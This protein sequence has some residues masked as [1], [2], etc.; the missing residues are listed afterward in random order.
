MSAL[1][2][3]FQPPQ[4]SRNQQI[5]TISPPSNGESPYCWMLKPAHAST[6]DSPFVESASPSRCSMRVDRHV[7][8]ATTR[9]GTYLVLPNHDHRFLLPLL[10]GYS[11]CLISG[12]LVHYRIFFEFYLLLI[13]LLVTTNASNTSIRC[14]QP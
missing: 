5:S 7:T 6:L 12:L 10:L 8:C 1:R 14:F 9:T 4:R 3:P 2:L 13:Q 11:W